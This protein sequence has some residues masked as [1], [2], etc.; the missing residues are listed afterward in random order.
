MQAMPK[1]DETA[2]IT[3]HPHSQHKENP[4]SQKNIKRR[5]LELPFKI[6][7]RLDR[8]R[9]Q[10][11]RELKELRKEIK[12]LKASQQRTHDDTNAIRRAISIT[13]GYADLH[14]MIEDM[15]K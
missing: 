1:R 2:P 9:R 10:H 5:R 3:I 15:N 11:A 4:M 7:L 12:N 13:D 8:N 6:I 14:L